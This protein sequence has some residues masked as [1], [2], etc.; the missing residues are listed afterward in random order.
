MVGAW[1]AFACRGKPNG[2]DTPLW[3]PYDP[4]RRATMVFNIKSEVVDNPNAE[5][6]KIVTSYG[7]GIRRLAPIPEAPSDAP[8]SIA[9]LPGSGCFE[10]RGRV[11]GGPNDMA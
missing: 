5:V 7:D 9:G 8:Q 10:G 3:L 2:A 1:I 6:R 11:V 4:A